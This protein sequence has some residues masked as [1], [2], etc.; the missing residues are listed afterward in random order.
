MYEENKTYTNLT[1]FSIVCGYL[2]RETENKILGARWR[3]SVTSGI[4]LRCVH[5]THNEMG[6]HTKHYQFHK[7]EALALGLEVNIK[8]KVHTFT[9]IPIR[10]SQ[11]D[12]G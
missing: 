5:S 3:G 8:K 11:L 2:R 7:K 10:L 12:L 6:K 9:I 4:H 1:S